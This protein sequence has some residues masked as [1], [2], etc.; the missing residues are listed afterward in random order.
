MK[1]SK[2]IYVNHMYQLCFFPENIK[3]WICL[4]WTLKNNIKLKYV[5]TFWSTFHLYACYISRS[6]CYDLQGYQ[7][8]WH[9]TYKVSQSVWSA[10]KYLLQASLCQ[11]LFFLQNMGRTCCVQKI[12]WMSET[13]SVHN[14]FSPGLSEEFSCIE[15]VIQW[16]SCRQILG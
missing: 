4:K 6:S 14:M 8:N 15:L 2:N 7:W 9:F 10:G 3:V 1:N 12:F 11:K 13:I 5:G 16:T